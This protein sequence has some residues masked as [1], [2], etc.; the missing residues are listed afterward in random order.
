MEMLFGFVLSMSVTMA[1]IPPLMKVAH[2]AQILD[3]PGLRKVH[4]L[5]T[6]RVGGIAMAAGVLLAL[7]L[8]GHFDRL[9]Q[10]YC[11]GV[12]I[13]LVFGVWDDRVGL[14]AAP[15]L[16]GQA[17][18][19][20]TA[21]AW[22]GVSVASITLSDRVA[23]PEWAAA[24]LSFFF[25]IG[26]T[27]AINLSD[28]LD[29][30][31]GGMAFLCTAALALLSLTVGNTFVAL[32]ALVIAGAILG[33]LRFNTHPA[34]V[35][36]G[37]S[38]S[39]VLGFSVAVLSVALTQDP[40][41]PLSSALPLLLL[42]MPIIDTLTV[43]IRRVLAG[44][45]PFDADRNHIHHRLL[46]LGLHHHEA[47]ML[48]YGLQAGL[49]VLAWMLRYEPDLINLL[50]FAGVFA[51]ILLVLQVAARYRPEAS[52]PRAESAGGGLGG[53]IDWLQDASRLPRWSGRVIVAAL[54]VYC[55]TVLGLAPSPDDEIGLFALV[56]AAALGAT[57]IFRWRQPAAGWVDKG[58]LY[59][60]AVLAIYLDQCGEPH[61]PLLH[62]IQWILFPL[63]AVAV[64]I[65]VQWPRD[66]GFRINPLD[67]LVIFMAIA[68]P[69][70]PG[71]VATPRALGA[72]VG[73]LF[74]LLY[75]IESLDLAASPRWRLFS[76]SV[77]V[78]LLLCAARAV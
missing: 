76:L 6:P 39:Q 52:G 5:P 24:P 7:I 28:G 25:L 35:F 4:N 48:I 73:K 58:A 77:L 55:G 9:L 74:L 21:M 40:R 8:W 54:A 29:G 17:L 30:L 14:G 41:A 60:G 16:L 11:A 57:L 69:N 10:A 64:A 53:R 2:R 31:A 34:R 46:G 3:H 27:N 51:A 32:V 75:G 22:G 70:L 78:F 38:G 71:S 62:Y 15:K 56:I 59:I 50:V 68:I 18:A 45:S 63:L 33:F 20:V 13:L 72:V 44:R 1:L 36:M 61:T 43:M 19:V 12:L 67:L 65:R 66:R 47:V 42:G 26:V 37:D 23:L 49:F